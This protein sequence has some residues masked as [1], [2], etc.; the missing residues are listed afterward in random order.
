MAPRTQPK[1]YILQI[2]TQKLSIHLILQPTTTIA[3]LKQEV[4]DALMSDVAEPLTRVAGA[5]KDLEDDKM[6]EDFDFTLPKDTGL[7]K[8]E[9]DV[10]PRVSSLQDFEL[11]K[12]VKE[13]GKMTGEFQVLEANDMELKMSGLSGWEVLFVQF[14]NKKSGL[15]LPAQFTLPPIDDDDED[16]AT[17]QQ[18]M[19]DFEPSNASLG[20]RKA[21]AD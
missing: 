9:E 21:R 15:L 14:R 16:L 17:Q 7:P 18:S 1:I 11:C 5:P 8:T 6:D 4:F 3:E 19:L 20:K 2:K 12:A 10:V 13:K